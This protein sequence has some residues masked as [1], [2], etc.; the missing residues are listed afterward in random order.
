M[1]VLCCYPSVYRM[2]ESFPFPH[3]SLCDGCLLRNLI[4]FS[5]SEIFACKIDKNEYCKKAPP[6]RCVGCVQS[7]QDEKLRLTDG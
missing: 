1:A 6:D 2:D 7:I 5:Q 3:K 4:I